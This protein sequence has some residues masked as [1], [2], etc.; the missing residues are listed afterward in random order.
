[1]VMT[2]WAVYPAL[3]PRFPAGLSPA[4][5]QGELRRRLG[6][7]GVTITD[8][9][10]AGALDP[11]GDTSAR[12]LLAAQAGMDVLLCSGRDMTQGTDAVQALAAALRDHRLNPGHSRQALRR[13]L[14]LR[15]RLG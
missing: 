5:V 12:V 7:R 9:I 8:A 15:E 10:E 6:F 4:I 13:V 11:F 2:S 3:D 1:M 14:S